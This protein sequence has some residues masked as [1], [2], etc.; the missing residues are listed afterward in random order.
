[1]FSTIDF[2]NNTQN[3]ATNNHST[4]RGSGWSKLEQCLLIESYAKYIDSLE[5]TNNDQQK[6]AI[7]ARIMS[8]YNQKASE[9]RVATRSLAEQNGKW[10]RMVKSFKEKYARRHTSGESEFA[11]D[12]VYGK[13]EDLLKRYPTILPIDSAE[14]SN[15]SSRPSIPSV[16]DT[17]HQRPDLPLGLELPSTRRRTVSPSATS[18]T[19]SSAPPPINPP[20]VPPPP[21]HKS[22]QQVNL[23][24]TEAMLNSVAGSQQQFQRS[25]FEI[26]QASMER[27][28]D[29]DNH[30]AAALI[31]SLD[32]FSDIIEQN[33]LI[34]REL[35]E[36]IRR[37]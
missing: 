37:Q 36:E 31:V 22:R 14:L 13:L 17:E 9:N 10:K 34:I 5:N 29:L 21:P 4:R 32:R 8:D 25:L 2:N 30:I 16:S 19:L 3:A 1:M 35:Y 28:K 6:G 11:I 27:R 20:S 7:K 23:S 26:F 12:S 18:N 33:G 15:S 24:D